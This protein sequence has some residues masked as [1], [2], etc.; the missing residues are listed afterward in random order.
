MKNSENECVTKLHRMMQVD[1]SADDVYD[2][3]ADSWS[4]CSL[5]SLEVL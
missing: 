4:L 5:L 3:S 2:L 1:V